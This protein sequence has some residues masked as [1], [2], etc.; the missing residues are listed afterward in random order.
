MKKALSPV[1]L[2]DGWVVLKRPFFPICLRQS[3]ANSYSLTKPLAPVR[4][5][6]NVSYM[7][8]RHI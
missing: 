3:L 8:I 6:Q 1:P 2:I 7:I 4:D 5:A